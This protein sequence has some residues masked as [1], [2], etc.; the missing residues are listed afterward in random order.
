MYFI[1]FLLVH[2][3]KPKIQREK[4]EGLAKLKTHDYKIYLNTK[5]GGEYQAASIWHVGKYIKKRKR[6][7]FYS[8]G[9]ERRKSSVER[10]I[11]EL[12]DFKIEIS[13]RF[14]RS[15]FNHTYKFPRKCIQPK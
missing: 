3:T 6:Q 14:A 15:I 2:E 10:V 13:K 11:A 12:E 8:Q 4:S 7:R 5:P 1:I 9:R